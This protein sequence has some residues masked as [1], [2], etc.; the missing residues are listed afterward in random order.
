[1]VFHKIDIEKYSR[2]EY[3]NHYMN[4]N[5]CTFSITVKLDITSLR[6]QNIKVYPSLLYGIARVINNHQEFRLALNE[7]GELGYFDIM[8]P[9][10]TIFHK[11]S[12]TF[13][14]IWTEYNPSFTEFLKNYLSDKNEYKNDLAINPKGNPPV[15]T[16]PVSMIPWTTFDGFNL[17]IKHNY[18]YLSPIITMG[19]FM[20]ENNNV[21]LPFAIQIHHASCDAFHVSR[22]LNE[23]QE[24]INNLSC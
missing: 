10:Y 23:L 16:F 2:K 20:E 21:L 24:I 4:V 8:N 15:N 11:D 3:Y 6:K 1:M 17:N 5:P 7:K 14:N 9:C 13:S 18:E 22:F 12:E 19:K